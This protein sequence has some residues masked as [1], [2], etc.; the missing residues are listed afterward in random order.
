MIL[1]KEVN[2]K[3]LKSNIK[4]LTERGYSTNLGD[5]LSIKIEE[6]SKNSKAIISAKCDFCN[7]IKEIQYKLY[8]KSLK[9]SGKFSCSSKCAHL[10]RRE[11]LR[12][13]FG[14]DNLSNLPE[15][16]EKRKQTNIEKY[17]F[18]S[19]FKSPEF[20]E[21]NK[22]ILLEKYGVD[23]YTKTEEY[24]EKTKDTNLKKY[25]KEWYLQTE[26]KFE[27]SKETNIKKWGVECP[28]KLES[29]K[30]K[31]LETNLI[32]Y[33]FK[34]PMMSEKIKEKSKETLLKNYGVDNPMKSDQIKMSSKQTNIDK[35]G[36]EY[37][38]QNPEVKKKRDMNNI[39]KWGVPNAFLSEEI[40]KNMII[41]KHPDYIKYLYGE[42]SI[43]NC[44]MGH[45]FKIKSDNFYKRV[46]YNI[47]L[48][49]VCNPI[50][51]SASTKENEL[52]GYILSIYDGEIIQS[53]RDGL[54]IDI[55]LP[56]LKLGFEF[57][58]LWWHSEEYKTKDYHLNKSNYFSDRG[59]RLIHIWEDD[60]IKKGNILKSQLNNWIGKTIN[61]IG[62]RRCQIGEVDSKLA[63]EFLNMN[64]I[65]GYVNSILK[66]GLYFDGEL[67]SL[68]TFDQFEGRKKMGKNEW[69]LSRFC[70][71]LGY[72]VVG[73]ASKILNYFVNSMKPRRIISYSDRDWS[74]GGLYQKLNFSKISE[75]NP[76]YKYIS[77]G[78]RVNKSRF[79]KGNLKTNLTE[80]KFMKNMGYL[81]IWDCGKSKWEKL[82]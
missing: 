30:L 67:V 54:E 33:G 81:K 15:I 19:I 38:I 43:F 50:G 10:K 65:Q 49:T 20:K 57:N 28:Q 14:V 73:G 21:K 48:C 11:I 44:K 60:W 36:F 68:M 35:Y 31:T 45:D 76:D 9:I 5:F 59:I 55:Y 78:V 42:I 17:G 53:Y 18:D 63:K 80:S 7:S 75:S 51:D 77:D 71:K 56:E 47:P 39:D 6:L 34:S 22:N 74:D 13:K 12:E 4:F 32:K 27:K 16:I 41:G 8:N 37:P 29:F 69:N 25:G 26:D 66:L 52:Y 23:N 64:H 3:V 24:K 79:R 72:N 58:G 2:I 70:N 82:L 62:A 40:R 46:K 1:T 61:R